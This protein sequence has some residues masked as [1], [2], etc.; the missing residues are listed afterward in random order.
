MITQVAAAV[1]ISGVAFVVGI[2]LAFL[3]SKIVAFG[4]CIGIHDAKTYLERKKKVN[5][6]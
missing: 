3:F 2:V 5:D 1:V 6:A 4:I